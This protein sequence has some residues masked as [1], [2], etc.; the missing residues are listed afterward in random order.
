MDRVR[1]SRDRIECESG[2]NACDDS[3]AFEV[4]AV[5]PVPRIL[6]ACVALWAIAA[7]NVFWIG[8][9]TLYSPD[10][11]MRRAILHEAILVGKLPAG[12]NSWS[13]LGANSAAMRP[14]VSWI[15]DGLVGAGFSLDRSYQLIEF[16]SIV[17][18]LALL[19]ELMK[20]STSTDRAL[21][22]CGWV[23][24]VLPLSY[25]L[26]YFHPWDKPS[27]ALW[28]IA[29]LL[30]LDDR[31]L[32]ASIA[33]ALAVLVKFD[34]VVLPLLYVLLFAGRATW[35]RFVPRL[36][37]LTTAAVVPF[38]TLVMLRPTAAE[39]RDVG[40]Q[41][42]VNVHDFLQRWYMYPPAIGLVLPLALG[43]V[44]FRLAAHAERALYVLALVILL[45]LLLTTNF[46]EIRAEFVPLVLMLPC[47]SRGLDRLLS[48]APGSTE[49]AI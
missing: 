42:A 31:I 40:Q 21:L 28:L 38:T 10:L 18:A 41:L 48:T 12:V 34:A 20:R 15:A 24:A 39:P 33:I 13:S 44:G 3:T 7:T 11:E 25:F 43:A 5:R 6:G 2:E 4:P 26:H 37:V 32:F 35:K 9:A 49:R 19:F 14:L 45:I 46:V 23:A 8:S 47:A 22:A 1:V 16:V 29:V 36:T 17:A 27:L 30:M